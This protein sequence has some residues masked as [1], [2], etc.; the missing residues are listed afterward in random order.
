[1][2][3]RFL[4][5][6]FFAAFLASTPAPAQSDMSREQ[7]EAIVASYIK[8][9]PD[10]IGAIVK[11]YVLRHPEVLREI[12]VELNR[13]KAPSPDNA[14]QKPD[15]LAG[16]RAQKIGANAQSLFSS[17]HQATLGDPNGDVT[18]VEF[19]DYNC[20]YCKRALADT[21]ALLGEDAHLRLAL[22]DFPILGPRSV[23]AAQVAVAAR[24]QD[25][26]SDRYF[27]FHRRLLGLRQ[28]L[29]QE[30]ALAAARES[31]FDMERLQR[32][33]TSEEVIATL[34]ENMTLAS[35]LH[36]S[37]TPAY[38][39]GDKVFVGAIGLDALKAEI[40]HLRQRA[41]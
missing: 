25:A 41:P 4:A 27:A 34:K 20:G 26:Q 14:A 31:G 21:V 40:A 15:P 13:R 39:A 30:A 33:M 37:G 22:K 19:F 32:D 24:M 9:H 6:V 23:D 2:N 16:E 18:L 12:F 28:P 7:V 36:I 5:P 11:D 17:P 35:L 38:V 3:I 10:E 1:M 8:A 29:T